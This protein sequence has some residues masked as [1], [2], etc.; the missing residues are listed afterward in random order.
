MKE[1]LQ[2]RA[3]VFKAIRAFL[4]SEG[5]TEVD[6]PLFVASPDTEPS[7]EPFQTEW[8]EQGHSHIGYLTPSPEFLLKRA[9]AAGSRL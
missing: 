8:K 5:F 6:S 1:I 3:T 9:L 4:D 2:L 7:I